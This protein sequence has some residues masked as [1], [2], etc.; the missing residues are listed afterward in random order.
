MLIRKSKKASFLLHYANQTPTAGYRQ[1][2]QFPKVCRSANFR[3]PQVTIFERL[4]NQNKNLDCKPACLPNNSTT[5]TWFPVIFK[6]KNFLNIFRTKMRSLLLMTIW[7]SGLIITTIVITITTAN[8]K[9][10]INRSTPWVKSV[11]Y[12][13]LFILFIYFYFILF[14]L[15]YFILFLYL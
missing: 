14:I 4:S 8:H 7:I 5:G 2:T 10:I 3:C 15:F 1:F 11:I 6:N 9:Q 13:D 12:L